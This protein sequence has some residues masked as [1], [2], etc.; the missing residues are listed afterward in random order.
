M[1]RFRGFS[2][3]PLITPWPTPDRGFLAPAEAVSS[4][5]SGF[6]FP[7]LWSHHFHILLFGTFH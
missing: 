7:G 4:V 6:M 2:G 5:R 3:A 1:G